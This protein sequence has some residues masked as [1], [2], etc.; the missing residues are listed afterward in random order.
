MYICLCKGITE[1]KVEKALKQGRP[2][3]EVLNQ[4]GIGN[5]CGTCLHHALEYLKK[6]KSPN[7]VC[8]KK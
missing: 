4:L 8:K 7:P 6:T 2:L 5:D 1:E 3:K